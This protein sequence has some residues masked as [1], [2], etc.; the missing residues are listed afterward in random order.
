M[1]ILIPSSLD[2]TRDELIKEWKPFPKQALF[3]SIPDTIKEAFYGGGAGSA[4]TETIMMYPIARSWYKNPGFKQVILRTTH[5]EL[6]KEIVPRT[7]KIYPKFGA[8]W[9]GQD[10]AWTFP[11]PDQYGAGFRAN[12]GATIYLSH[13][14]TDD[15]VHNFDGME[16]NCFSPDEITSLTAYKYLYIGFTRTRAALG[17]GLPAVIRAGGMPGDIGHTWVKQR[18]VDHAPKGSK[19]I[20]GRGGNKRIY[21]FANY[22][23][24]PHLGTQYGI[25]L[26]SLPEAEKRAKLG[27]WDAYAGQVFEEFRDRQYS[28]E[29]EEFPNAL[30]VIPEFAIPSWWPKMVIGDWG[31]AAQT[32]VGFFAISPTGRLYLYRELSW[33]KTKIADWA[34]TVKAFIDQEKPK[35]I[36]FCKSAGQ[37]RGQEHTIQQQ[38]E[39][40][41]ERPIELSTNTAGS[42]IAGKLLVHEYL[43]WKPKPIIPASELPVYDEGYS[44]WLL[45][46]KGEREYKSYLRIFDPPEDEK[47]I[48]KLQIFEHCTLTIQA[49]KSCSY[50]KAT[51]EGKAAEDVAEFPGDDP[52][53]ALRYAVDSAER[54]VTESADE[55]KRVQKQEELIK[56]LENTHDW[57]A[58]YRNMN[59]LEIADKPKVVRMMR[60]RRR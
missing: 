7:K 23:D 1:D 30:H 57:T 36:K 31:F 52:Y 51:K 2:D 29:E 4:K 25:D 3:L 39:D 33:T 5:P 34:P 10:M 32:F 9:N 56:T 14:E 12:A 38:I 40:E 16:I 15:D 28:D 24:N 37:D 54:Y 44:Q 48:P 58:Y 47:N 55:F 18:F 27:D 50:A 21:I 11:S 45:R 22:K 20:V 19:V 13:C 60:R 6:K 49:I 35:V 46:N 59:S 17:S 53:D 41:L 43:R 26:E 8:T 42:R